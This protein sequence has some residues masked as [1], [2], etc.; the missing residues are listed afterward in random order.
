M[1]SQNVLLIPGEYIERHLIQWTAFTLYTFPF[2]Q[3]PIN[4]YL[5]MEFLPGG[6]P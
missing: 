1:D 5:I 6:E 3:D 2:F 4:L